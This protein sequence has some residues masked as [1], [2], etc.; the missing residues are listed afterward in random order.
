MIKAQHEDNSLSKLF[1]L[2][3]KGETTVN[4]RGMETGYCIRNQ[5]LYRDFQ[6]PHV[7]FGQVVKQ[8]VVPKINRE[9][10]MSVAHVPSRTS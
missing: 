2:A 3:T 5:L 4:D 8:L 6:S 1:D 10:V 9:K 7:Q